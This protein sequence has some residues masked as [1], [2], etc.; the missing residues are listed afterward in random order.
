MLNISGQIVGR[1][2]LV[3]EPTTRRFKDPYGTLI[4]GAPFVVQPDA[5]GHFSVT[6]FDNHDIVSMNSSRWL[7]KC[8]EIVGKGASA[9][10]YQFA[11]SS[12]PGDYNY[13]ELR[14]QGVGL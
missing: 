12:D 6:L 5:H 14:A 2:R 4:I 3:F 13:A 7:W 8:T 1:V 11:F 9:K 10:R